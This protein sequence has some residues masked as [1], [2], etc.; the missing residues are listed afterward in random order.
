M[1]HHCNRLSYD[2]TGYFSS[3]VTDY[4]AQAATLRPFYTHLPN[5][6][7]I[8]A[9]IRVREQ[10]ATPRNILVDSL[11][12][13]YKTVDTDKAV[14]DNIEAL[15]STK[16]FTVV[17]AH[18]PNIFTGPLYFV[19][20]ILHAI[21]LAKQ[22]SEQMP[23]YRFVP[24]YYMGSEDADLDELG[25]ISV[26][27]NKL[28][29]ATKQTGAVGRMI[30]DKELIQL[31]QA[32]EG[33]T[34]VWPFGKELS[35]VFRQ[36]YTI[37]RTI[38]EATLQL[39]NTLFGR[40]GLVVLIPDQHHLKATFA[41][42]VE[43]ELKEGFSHRAVS[44]TISSLEKHYKVQTGGREINL[45]YLINDRRERIE[46]DGDDYVVNA[47]DLRFTTTAI[48][49]ELKTYPERFSPNV[50]LR[51]A[52]QETI[53]PNIAFIGG[54]GEL[55]YWMELKQVFVEIQVPFPVLVLRN[56]FLIMTAEQE[57]R[58]KQLEL[59]Y[60]SLFTKAELLLEQ[61]VKRKTSSQLEVKEE[62]VQLTALYETMK[63]KAGAIDR[64]LTAH[65][66]ALLTKASKQLT[67]LEKK[68][69]RAEKR[70]F[71]AEERQILS[72]KE[73]LFP[74]D[75]LQE[76]VDNLSGWYARYGK[77]WIDMLLHNSLSL[78]SMFVLLTID[79]D[80]Q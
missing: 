29:W 13:Q 75:S 52:F 67:G 59:N 33:Q 9:A 1:K 19:Y 65:V 34:G 24:V 61:L 42:V 48:L 28:S 77:D 51:G 58:M 12:E 76:R 63:Q 53:L 20:K 43:K 23:A 70:K 40:F 74:N 57:R 30:V 16:T 47:L 38:Q 44:G 5:M 10:F 54:G 55:A 31:L 22:L 35:E 49:E 7:G 2:N 73:Q 78:E 25:Q 62:L 17:T 68:M 3:L 72:L 21:Q 32:I 27:G 6:E 79:Q 69:L 26:D 46:K 4:L 14:A 50:I 45:F 41:A 39:V 15:T 8:E 71:E 80:N 18:Q 64:T 56:S 66:D 37:G 36:A 60:H 11:R